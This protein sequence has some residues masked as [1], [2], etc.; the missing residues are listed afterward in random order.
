[1]VVT[2]RDRKITFTRISNGK[3]DDKS[4]RSY[5]EIEESVVC[6]VAFISR[7]QDGLSV[8][9]LNFTNAGQSYL[10]RVVDRVIA[11]D[12]GVEL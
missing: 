2:L 3:A 5:Y 12:S 8:Q 7:G 11:I 10:V 4:F 6:H 9:F 1:M